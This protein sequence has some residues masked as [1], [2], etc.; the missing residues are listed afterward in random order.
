M[1][2]TEGTSAK[3]IEVNLDLTDEFS[4]KGGAVLKNY[5]PAYSN[6]ISTLLEYEA[7][8]VV[9]DVLDRYRDQLPFSI[10]QML[11]HGRYDV[12][13]DEDSPIAFI[14]MTKL[15]NVLSFNDADG[16]G[17]E[18][19]ARHAYEAG[20]VAANL[21]K[22]NISDADQEKLTRDMVEITVS[23]LQSHPMAEKHTMHI[24]Q[25]IQLLRTAEGSKVFVHG[26]LHT[27]NLCAENFGKNIT[28]VLD[29]ATSA[30]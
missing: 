6:G 18:V 17:S 7:E 3:V 30:I 23:R 11:D 26:D 22:L 8:V 21:H 4:G 25:V 5:R 13:P 27:E 24:D 15:N 29:F 16:V 2:M 9:L 12:G 28:G 10:P 19:L 1:S 14:K 20:V